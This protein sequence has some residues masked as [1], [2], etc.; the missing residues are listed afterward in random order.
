MRDAVGRLWAL[1]TYPARWVRWRVA[2][3]EVSAQREQAR[4]AFDAV[5]G[6]LEPGHQVW[7][8]AA[9]ADATWD[10]ADRC[11]RA[12]SPTLWGGR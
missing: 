12:V 10:D 8:D 1:V 2:V 3:W 6:E 7:D 9:Y 11:L 4:A 5:F